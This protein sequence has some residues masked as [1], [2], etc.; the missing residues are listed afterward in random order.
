M[1][2]FHSL[3]ADFHETWRN[4]EELSV[5]KLNLLPSIFPRNVEFLRGITGVIGKKLSTDYVTNGQCDQESLFFLGNQISVFI[6]S[7]SSYLYYYRTS[8]SPLVLLNC[9][10]VAKSNVNSVSMQL[11]FTI[12]PMKM[13]VFCTAGIYSQ[14]V[15]LLRKPNLG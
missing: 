7:S 12:V 15:Q 11:S 13:S 14:V 2:C 9:T 1:Q 6:Y 8:S 10:S 3:T 5:Y 4:L